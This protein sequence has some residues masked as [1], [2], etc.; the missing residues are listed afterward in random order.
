MVV[1]VAGN[2]D[3]GDEIS[4]TCGAAESGTAVAEE[5]DVPEETTDNGREG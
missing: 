2:G 3:D 5:G 4:A 1:A